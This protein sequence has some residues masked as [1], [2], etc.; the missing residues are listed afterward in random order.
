MTD[1][2]E[3]G[4]AESYLLA[5]ITEAVKAYDVTL[6]L[7][8]RTATESFAADAA[9]VGAEIEFVEVVRGRGPNPRGIAR[10]ARYLRSADPEVVH[11]N[12][13]S[14]RRCA[15]SI[16]GARIAGI[17]KRIATFHLAPDPSTP[18]APIASL[19][20]LNRRLRFGML[21]DAITVSHENEWRLTAQHQVPAGRLHVVPNGVDVRR[22]APRPDDGRLRGQW[23][24]PRSAQLL[25]VVARLNRQKG[26]EV[27][28]DAMVDVW[29]AVPDAY[30]VIVGTGELDGDLRAQAER[31]GADGRIVFAGHST[32]PE[33]V[34]NALD[35]AV[36]PSLFEGMPLTAIE[37]LAA[38]VPIVATAVGGTPEVLEDGVSGLLVPPRDR[39]ALAQAIASLLRDSERC[40]SMGTAGRKRALADHDQSAMVERTLA[41]YG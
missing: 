30:L 3:V 22:F 17:P 34:M 33:A 21:T 8:R 31:V 16:F 14:P 1:T 13:G 23:G 19:M 28:I 20:R 40:V 37:A 38:G 35:V 12:L 15:E 7:P 5:L 11:F 6:A 2:T 9:R 29:L 27:L 26:H 41:L 24:V 18:I 36:L 39:F 25:G 32:E 10:A 4:G